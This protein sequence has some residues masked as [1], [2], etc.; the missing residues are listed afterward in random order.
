MRKLFAC[1]TQYNPSNRVLPSRSLQQIPPHMSEQSARG[2][3]S[4]TPPAAPPSK[5]RA[6]LTALT[7]AGILRQRKKRAGAATTSGNGG[8]QRRSVS[9]SRPSVPPLPSTPQTLSGSVTADGSEGRSRRSSTSSAGP[10]PQGDGQ[11]G[12]ALVSVTAGAAASQ[13]SAAEPTPDGE[14]DKGAGAAGDDVDD[15]GTL[16][17]VRQSKEEVGELWDQMSDDQRQRYG[18]YRRSA[19]NKATVKRLIS[20]VLNQQVSSTL[21]FVVAGFAKVFVGEI[22]ERAVQ[23][24]E[25]RGDAGALK[26]E[27]LREAYRLYRRETQTADTAAT[28]FAKRMF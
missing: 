16:M 9:G 4:G 23:I 26:P 2:G 24:Q 8:A 5:K 18:V 22:V 13:G 7:P 12:A 11:P 25:E 14:H 27:H 19:L 10:P 28:G 6:R 15:D 21:T 1:G 3:A 17:L 20:Q